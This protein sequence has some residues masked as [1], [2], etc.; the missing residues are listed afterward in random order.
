MPISQRSS[1]A[2]IGA[3]VGPA[4]L[5]VEHHIGDPLAGSVIGELAAAPGAKDREARVDQVAVLGAGAGGVERRMLEEPDALGRGSV[6]DRVG[7]R[8]H[9]R[10]RVGVFGQSGRDDPF[11]RRRVMR[12][13]ERRVQRKAQ[14]EHGRFYQNASLGA[15]QLGT[16]T[17]SSSPA[18][19]GGI[20]FRSPFFSPKGSPKSVARRSKSLQPV[21]CI[22]FF[23]PET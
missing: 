12:G 20:D 9:L 19:V 3:H 4:A 18:E 5:E 10:Q 1:A 2:D 14:I 13:Q 11:D 8:F 15:S 21:A 6:R 22:M 23:A 16:R 7:A 17:I